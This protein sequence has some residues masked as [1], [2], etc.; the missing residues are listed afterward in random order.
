MRQPLEARKNCA[1]EMIEQCD[2]NIA[3]TVKC[4]YQ[5]GD[6]ITT[7][8]NAMPEQAKEY[9]LNQVFNIGSGEND[10][11][12]RCIKVEALNN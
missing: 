2:K 11:L 9:F 10:N 6:T 5:N 1:V 7:N 8:I 12:Q 3:L 4:T